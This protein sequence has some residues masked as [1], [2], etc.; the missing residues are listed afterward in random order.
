MD[1][2]GK[3]LARLPD[4]DGGVLSGQRSFA[5]EA[6]MDEVADK[7]KLNDER[8]SWQVGAS[9]NCGSPIAKPG[10]VPC[11]TALPQLVV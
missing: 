6:L 5:E 2:L 7:L 9:E 11:G 8:A 1:E 10:P 3:T 4:R